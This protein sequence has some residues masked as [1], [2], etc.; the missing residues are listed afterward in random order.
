MV[1]AFAK[2][3]VG[4]PGAVTVTLSIWTCPAVCPVPV[5]G[6]WPKMKYIVEL[7]HV[8]ETVQVTKVLVFRF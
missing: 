4:A 7:V 6:F 2:V 1:T 3:S 5:L 8:T